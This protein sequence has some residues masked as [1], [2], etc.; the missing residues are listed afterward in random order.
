MVLAACFAVMAAA[1]ITVLLALL[2]VLLVWLLEVELA[3][4]VRLGLSGLE[5][6]TLEL[7]A[8]G[9]FVVVPPSEEPPPQPVNAHAVSK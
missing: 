2:W 7:T 4:E 1:R 3:L 8:A 6:A 9:V 5:L